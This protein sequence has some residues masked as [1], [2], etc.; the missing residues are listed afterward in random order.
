MISRVM[1]SKTYLGVRVLPPLPPSANQ[2]PSQT[3][4]PEA[5]SD[6]FPP[7]PPLPT[8][9]PEDHDD[10]RNLQPSLLFKP[11]QDLPKISTQQ[12]M[13]PV[14]PKKQRQLISDA[15]TS[16]P[17]ERLLPKGLRDVLPSSSAPTPSPTPQDYVPAIRNERSPDPP[18]NVEEIFDG[19]PQDSRSRSISPKPMLERIELPDNTGSLILDSCKTNSWSSLESLLRLLEKAARVVEKRSKVT[20]AVNA[21]EE[22]T[23]VTALMLCAKESRAGLVDQ[24]LKLGA[25][26]NTATENGETALHFAVRDAKEE[27]VRMLVTYG[28]DPTI[29]GGDLKQL[30]LHL[31]CMRKF[32]AWPLV[33]YLVPLSGPECRMISDAEG[34]LPV[35]RAADV[36]NLHVLKELLL[37]QAHQQLSYQNKQMND[38]T[39]AHFVI[40]RHDNEVLK[41]LLEFDTPVDIQNSEGE[42]LLHVA[43]MV[44]NGDAVSMLHDKKAN[45]DLIDVMGRSALHL[46]VEQGLTNVVD[47]LVE[48]FR[49]SLK[50]RAKDGSTLAHIA[51][52][53]GHAATV[54]LLIRRGVPISMPNKSGQLA[55]HI[56]AQYGHAN[57]AS[58]LLANGT[59]VD[60][61]T[62]ENYTALHIA[63][64]NGHSLMVD[65]LIGSGAA[66]N[67]T[68]G[69]ESETA[70]HIAARNPNG[71]IM[72]ET[73]IKSGANPNLK[74]TSGETALHIA[75]KHGSLKVLK[76]VL[77]EN[78]DVSAVNNEGETALHLAV[79]NCQYDVAR[80]ILDHIS[81]HESQN[82]ASNAV[83]TQNLEGESAVHLVAQVTSDMVHF[84]GEDSMLAQLLLDYNGNTNLQ[85]KETLETPLHYCARYGC[86]E[87]LSTIIR[88]LGPERLVLGLNK[89][90]KNGWSPLL[91]A[92]DEGHA[93]I[94][95]ILLRNNARVDVFDE[96]GRAALHLAAEKDHLD[97][98]DLLLQHKAFVNA[99]NK[100]GVT[101]AHLAAER[102]AADIV[103]L[104]V[105]KYQANTDVLSLS[106][107][108]PLHLAAQAGQWG[109]CERLIRLGADAWAKDQKGQTPMH[110]AAAHNHAQIVQLFI[111]HKGELDPATII[112]QKGLNVAHTAAKHGCLEVIQLLLNHNKD[113]VIKSKIKSTEASAVHLAA[114][115]GHDEIVKL[116]IQSGAPA[117][118]ENKEG[119]TPLHLA[120]RYGHVKVLECLKDSVS[121][122]VCSIKT[123][124]TALHLA[125]F[126]GQVDFVRELLTTVPVT[127]VTEQPTVNNAMV[128]HISAEPGLT[129]LHLACHSG[130]EEMVRVL[131]NYPGV[132]TDA[133]SDV[134]GTTPLQ[135]AAI[136]GHL[137]IVNLLLSKLGTQIDKRDAK[138]RTAL[139]SACFHG[140]TEM[141][142][143]LIGQ[144]A[145][146]SAEDN[147]GWTP[148][149]HAAVAG[150]LKVVKVLVDSN[151]STV[152]KNRDGKIPLCLCAN[153][154]KTAVVLYL[155]TK[156]H[157]VFSL[158]DD[159]VFLLDLMLCSKTAQNKPL[160][161]FI[162]TSPS[163]VEVALK[164]A[165]FYSEVSGREKERE[166]DLNLANKFCE[167]LG[168][169]L[170]VLACNKFSPAGILRAVDHH[171]KSLMDILIEGEH[172]DVVAL[173]AVQRYLTQVWHGNQAW[174]GTKSFLIF[175]VFLLCPPVWL[176]FCL[177]LEHKYNYIPFIKLICH[178]VSHLFFI[179][180][181]ILVF[182]SPFEQLYERHDATPKPEEIILI[183]WVIGKFSGELTTAEERSGLGWIRVLIIVFCVVAFILHFIA[184]AFDPP[185]E[186]EVLYVRNQIFALSSFFACIQIVSFLSFHYMFGPFAIIIR[187]VVIDLLRFLV[188][189]VLF[190]TGFTFLLS[191]LYEDVLRPPEGFHHEKWVVMDMALDPLESFK[192]LYF[193][194]FGLVNPTDIDAPPFGPAFAEALTQIVYGV[195]LMVT[196]VVLINLLIAML[197]DT[198]Q[199]IQ[200]RSDLEWKYGRAKLVM[201]MDK[202]AITPPPLNTLTI[203]TAKLYAHFQDSRHNMEKLDG[204]HERVSMGSTTSH[205]EAVRT[206][207]KSTHESD[208]GEQ[209]LFRNMP[210]RKLPECCDWKAVV[211][212]YVTSDLLDDEDLDEEIENEI[213][214]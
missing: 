130:Q 43:T 111:Q 33:Q 189:L 209:Q 58:E 22:G 192:K 98:V 79:R 205:A 101:P 88:F 72:A 59:P 2:P 86:Y 173:P 18:H 81:R 179:L 113:L 138:G 162:I 178:I 127:T 27:M 42:T 186:T 57:V 185:V 123:G 104:L 191:S 36:A 63:V 24:L 82:A 184:F 53:S 181:L 110:L 136:N 75:A 20:E 177:P 139:M 61:R 145:D 167:Q 166:R 76:I 25:E 14:P 207:S 100:D 202:S 60:A 148:L 78:V 65:V 151:A 10:N 68:G 45:P 37:D 208:E 29:I 129:A 174:S 26:I 134:S 23:K 94:V 196:M 201:N 56:A 197:S 105:E 97:V 128:K 176:I 200:A 131:L 41:I 84:S 180:V 183:I 112:D 149:H 144:G 13:Q 153:A 161:E 67:I 69:K 114:A 135:K 5:D 199:R 35:W 44:K 96:E 118:E 50:T 137:S 38:D 39:L 21:A 122:N 156:P 195:Y 48:R 102:G 90:A 47:T 89:L 121:L 172:K 142:T 210:I 8:P 194:M 31:A 15:S 92:C 16:K 213:D 34:F 182:M 124:L 193:A 7:P 52:R 206:W 1:Q 99:K 211:A 103:E 175:M 132:N 66:V 170:L 49:G 204:L 146:L 168:N 64:E 30:P 120:A 17:P 157:D 55:L 40:R 164:L 171:D 133:S 154:S 212:G 125:A 6:D 187:D 117:T 28:A 77:S 54:M 19:Q 198:Y 160:Q 143:L 9:V 80:E 214:S 32:G 119:L 165:R 155:L 188:I 106:K 141:V 85:T 190:L 62:K 12:S 116:L 107:K 91:T 71:H 87:I 51:A 203:I 74:T 11:K 163:P 152:A 150:H 73:L 46:A 4:F 147:N 115:G 169:D 140:H 70:L 3:G 109:I 95:D 108:T 83:N 93:D 159:K 158:M 126:T